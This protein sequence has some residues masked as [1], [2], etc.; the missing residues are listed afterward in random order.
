MKHVI[1][2]L[3]LIVLLFGTSLRAQA[4]PLTSLQLQVDWV[5][6]AGDQTHWA[7]NNRCS[8]TLTVTQAGANGAGNTVIYS[9]T[10]D[11]TGG[12]NVKLTLSPLALY[13]VTLYSN[14][15]QM[16]IFSSLFSSMF[17]TPTP[18]KSL[19]LSLR[20]TRPQINGVD[21]AAPLA[22]D[23]TP[24]VLTSNTQVAIGF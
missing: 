19:Q 17:V 4:S 14:Y 20:L 18:V 7:D 12:L 13:T 10:T 15:Y 22:A 2:S 16:N 21:Q 23:A 24:P 3:G 9:G 11:V 1:R 6:A 5:N 8:C